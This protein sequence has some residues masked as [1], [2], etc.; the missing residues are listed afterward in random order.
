RTAPGCGCSL[1]RF[2][3]GESATEAYEIGGS[4]QH[5]RRAGKVDERRHE[6]AEVEPEPEPRQHDRDERYLK[7]GIGLADEE[8][9]R[10]ELARGVEAEKNVAAD[11]EEVPEDGEDDEPGRN[12]PG[13]PERDED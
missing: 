7:P 8:R 11:D 4:R 13:D 10:L 2:H 3:A 6:P 5:R 12:V 1:R 9:L